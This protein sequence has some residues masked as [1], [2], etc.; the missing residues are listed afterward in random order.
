MQAHKQYFIRT[1]CLLAQ[2]DLNGVFVVHPPVLAVMHSFTSEKRQ[3]ESE[4]EDALPFFSCLQSHSSPSSRD[5]LFQLH[6]QF[7]PAQIVAAVALLLLAEAESQG[8]GL[9]GGGPGVMDST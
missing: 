4:G 2:C 8:R 3:T 7:V 9:S 6:L 1:F 5:P